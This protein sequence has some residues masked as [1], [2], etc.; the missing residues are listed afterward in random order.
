MEKVT[1][2]HIQKSRWRR[3]LLSMTVSLGVLATALI[4][5]PAS[6]S[7]ASF[8]DVPRDHQF[9]NQITWLAQMRVTTGYADGTF[10]PRDSVTREAFA[11]F[12]YRL[13]GSPVTRMPARSPFVDVPRN[14]KFYREIVWLSQQGITRG[15]SDG[16]FRP[17]EEIS[18]EAVAAFL[19][20]LSGKPRFSPPSRSPFRDMSTRS[21]FYKEVSWLAKTGITTGYSDRTFRPKSDVSREAIAAFLY[22]GSTG[23]RGTDY[24]VY[25]VG[26]QIFPGTYVS[27]PLPDGEFWC[28]WERRSDSGYSVWGGP[29]RPRFP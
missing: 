25:T 14:A 12:L 28:Y 21:K 27:A 17:K 23:L 2:E 20:R 11:A 22:R 24:D 1:A 7:P 3:A 19:Y 9:R 6:A 16:T 5:G 13:G 4:G 8:S 18:R 15:W 29:M 10:R 26:E